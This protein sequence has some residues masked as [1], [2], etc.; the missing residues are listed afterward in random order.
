MTYISPMLNR[1]R[2]PIFFALLIWRELTT[3][4]GMRKIMS[5]AAM[6]KVVPEMAMLVML[7]H[8]FSLIS[9][10]WTAWIDRHWNIVKNVTTT[11][12]I[13][14]KAMPPYARPFVSLSGKIRM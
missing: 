2:I 1:R 10:L 13:T 3:G 4:I 6:L 14:R 7:R 11:C 12:D 8:C 9:R 5:S